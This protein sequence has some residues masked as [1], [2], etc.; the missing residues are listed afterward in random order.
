[1]LSKK[2]LR[3]IETLRAIRDGW[4]GVTRSVSGKICGKD[5]CFYSP[6]EITDFLDAVGL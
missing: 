4:S 1:M 5:Y 6:D 3:E 2:D